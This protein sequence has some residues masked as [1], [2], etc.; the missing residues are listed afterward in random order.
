MLLEQF[1][2][3]LQAVKEGLTVDRHDSAT[4]DIVVTTIKH[5]AD[6]GDLLQVKLILEIFNNKFLANI[7]V[8]R[9][10][11]IDDKPRRGDRDFY[12]LL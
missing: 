7:I 11:E 5:F 2:S 8:V 3:A 6:F 1:I 12:R 4:F 10:L 9:Y